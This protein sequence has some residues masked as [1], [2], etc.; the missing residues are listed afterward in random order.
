M[1]TRTETAMRLYHRMQELGYEEGFCTVVSTYLNTDFTAARMLGY[2][3]HAKHPSEADVAEELIA[4]LEDRQAIMDKKRAE[5]AQ[6]AYNRVL[7][8]GL[9]EDED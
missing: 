8:E 5:A 7:N 9:G 2:L 6:A 4:I 1:K 3:K